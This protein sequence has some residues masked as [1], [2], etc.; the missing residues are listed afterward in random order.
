MV[1]LCKRPLLTR[2]CLLLL[3]QRLLLLVQRRFL[4]RHSLPLCIQRLLLHR[5]SLLLLLLLHFLR[6]LPHPC[7]HLGLDPSVQYCSCLL[8]SPNLSLELPLLVHCLRRLLCLELSLLVHC[9]R[10]LLCLV[11]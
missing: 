2:Y 9:L 8:L 3:V 4:L 7:C 11:L 5:H 10:R 6:L 1:L